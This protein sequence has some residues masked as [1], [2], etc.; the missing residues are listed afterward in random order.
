MAAFFHW[1]LIGYKIRLIRKIRYNS[2]SLIE[3]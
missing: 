2:W 1:L 3:Y